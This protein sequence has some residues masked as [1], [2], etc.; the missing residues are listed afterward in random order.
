MSENKR[1]FE[2]VNDGKGKLQS[3][4]MYLDEKPEENLVCN[5]G[6]T[7][8]ETANEAYANMYKELLRR[9]KLLDDI[10]SD[11][12]NGN[13]ELISRYDKEVLSEVYTTNYY[14]GDKTY[15]DV[16]TVF[17]IFNEDCIPESFK[18]E[19][20]HAIKMLKTE[21]ARADGINSV[22]KSYQTIC[23]ELIERCYKNYLSIPTI[24]IISS[25]KKIQ[26][27]WR[28]NTS[29]MIKLQYLSPTDDLEFIGTIIKKNQT[30]T[31]NINIT[32]ESVDDL[33]TLL[34][35]LSMYEL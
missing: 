24:C 19:Y 10:L 21:I 28:K 4:E 12:T 26:I 2:Y 1:Q 7:Y 34:G 11:M 22:P 35:I 15:S 31:S 9:K 23:Y 5:E 32:L 3:H 25:A 33:I 17:S 29:L 16:D 13:V 20:K 30:G 8:G 14:T 27:T 18:K 6:V